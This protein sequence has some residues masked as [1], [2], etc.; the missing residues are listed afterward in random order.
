MIKTS[1]VSGVSMVAGLNRNLNAFFARQVELRVRV[2]KS[3]ND[4]SLSGADEPGLD[5]ISL[6]K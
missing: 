3:T 2:R 5:L 4:F 6:M 1:P